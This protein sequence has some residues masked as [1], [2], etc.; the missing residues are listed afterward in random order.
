MSGGDG[1]IDPDELA[2]FIASQIE[3][4]LASFDPSLRRPAIVGSA[5]V[6]GKIAA[7]ISRLDSDRQIALA[8]KPD[9]AD[10]AIS[11]LIAGLVAEIP[12]RSHKRRSEE[13]VAARPLRDKGLGSDLIVEEWAGPVA[14]PTFLEANYGISRSS[15]HRWQRRNYVI[16]LRSGGR[17]HVFPLAQFIDGRPA[18]GIAAVREL[19]SNP[20]LAW[21]WLSRPNPAT[22]GSPPIELL[23]RDLVD[24]VIEAA[25]AH[26]ATG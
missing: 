15:L 25:R 13:T 3:Q 6:A 14:G 2:S 24:E 16:G 20:R 7:A 4:A 5:S 17:K 26:I 1:R 19:I 23:K 8:G 12:G 21:L 18:S 11:E 9:I 22:N 10:R